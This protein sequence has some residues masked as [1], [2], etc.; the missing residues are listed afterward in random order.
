M[1]TILLTVGLVSLALGGGLYV[2][3]LMLEQRETF[4]GDD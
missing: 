2:Y 4:K 1:A 3:L